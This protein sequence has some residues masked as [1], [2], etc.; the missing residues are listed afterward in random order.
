MEGSTGIRD[1][2]AFDKIL[3]EQYIRQRPSSTAPH[4]TNAQSIRRDRKRQGNSDQE[5]A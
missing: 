4:I 2:L 5:G 1:W 3:D